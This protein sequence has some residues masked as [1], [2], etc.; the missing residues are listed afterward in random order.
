GLFSYQ[1]GAHWTPFTDAPRSLTALVPGGC[2]AATLAV[3]Q[4]NCINEGGDYNLDR[5]TND[6]PNSSVTN[7]NPSSAQWAD[8]WGGAM[9][10]PG[11]VATNIFSTPCLGC[12]GT[13]GRNTFVGPSFFGADMS[14]FK[15]IPITERVKLQFRW[16]VF[17]VFNKT[18]F[19]LPGAN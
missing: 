5:I 16:D 19:Q 12:I 3:T 15:N 13:L 10:D 9:G 18:N 6:R 11:A 17:N 4:A 1:A 14:L 7:F 8:G 2:S